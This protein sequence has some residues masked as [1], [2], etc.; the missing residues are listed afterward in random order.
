M[1]VI[2]REVLFLRGF[3]SKKKQKHRGGALKRQGVR[4]VKP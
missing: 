2:L 4:E 1:Y 3:P